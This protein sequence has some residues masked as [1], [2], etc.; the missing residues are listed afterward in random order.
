M[1][2]PDNSTVLL[3]TRNGIGSTTDADLQ[4]RLAKTYFG[5]LAEHDILPN[6]ICFYTDGVRLV[7]EGS[8]VLDEL[9]ALEAKGV[10]LIICSTC[11][12]AFGLKDSVAVG[13]VGGMPDIVDAQWR[14]DK[15]IT[16]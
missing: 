11:L 5:L 2:Q 6:A 10:R 1:Q 3:V 8:P 14:A 13:I 4:H 12:N 9:R 15:V 7:C 16:L